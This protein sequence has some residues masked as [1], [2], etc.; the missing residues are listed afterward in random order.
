VSFTVRLSGA[1]AYT[2]KSRSSSGSWYSSK[3]VPL[4]LKLVS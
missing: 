3:A 2:V 4:Y 1:P